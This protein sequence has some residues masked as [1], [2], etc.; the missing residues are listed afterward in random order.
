[1]RKKTRSTRNGSVSSTPSFDERWLAPGPATPAGEFKTLQ[2][3]EAH[4]NETE[5]RFF[6]NILMTTGGRVYG[7]H[8]AAELLSIKPTTLQSR[9]KAL[10]L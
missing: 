3:V 10:G 1:M 9:L 2:E 7:P 4:L 6:Q 5:K 8:G